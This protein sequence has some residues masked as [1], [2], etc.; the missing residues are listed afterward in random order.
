[1]LIQSIIYN[2]AMIEGKMKEIDIKAIEDIAVGQAENAVAGTGCT[3]LISR[4]GM[5]PASLSAA[6]VRHPGSQ[7]C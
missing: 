6:A 2:P 4:A 1:M 7:S 5:P 3:V